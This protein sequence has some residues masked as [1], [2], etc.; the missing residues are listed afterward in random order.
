MKRFT[1]RARQKTRLKDSIT[2]LEKLRSVAEQAIIH[3]QD[4]LEEDSQKPVHK[5]VELLLP[6][7]INIEKHK[8]SVIYWLG[9]DTDALFL[10]HYA[11]FKGYQ[12]RCRSLVLSL[13]S[14]MDH[15]NDYR[16]INLCV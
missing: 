11:Y 7:Y 2:E 9:R 10:P 15:R 6:E 8:D 14:S 3:L 16:N 4:V 13:H 5:A 12:Q 1:I